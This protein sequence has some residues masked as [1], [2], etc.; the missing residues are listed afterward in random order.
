M[1][2]AR[3]EPRRIGR[4]TL[5][6]KLASGG[7]ATVFLAQSHGERG[8]L[9]LCAVKIIH[10]HLLDQPEFL[11]R[12]L[13]EGQVA[14][15]I[16]HP[17]VVAVL[18]VGQAGE[19]PYLVLDYVR[20]GSL[21]ELMKRADELGEPPSLEVACTIVR[22]VLEG[23]HAVHTALDEHGAPL[24]LIHRDVSHDNILLSTDGVAYVT[25]LGIA[26]ARG[27]AL[28]QATGLLGKAGYISPEQLAKEPLTSKVDVFAAGVVLWELLTQKRLFVDLEAELPMLTGTFDLEPPS[29]SNP[30]VPAALDG[31]VA[32]M[33]AR[34]PEDRPRSAGAAAQELG[35]II[36]TA[37]RAEISEWVQSLAEA[38]LER[39]DAI[40][41]DAKQSVPPPPVES[42][43]SPLAVVTRM[44]SGV[45]FASDASAPLESG[46]HPKATS[47]PPPSPR[48]AARKVMTALA[49]VSL[50]ALGGAGARYG[51]LARARSTRHDSPPPATSATVE[52]PSAPVPAPPSATVAATAAASSPA[53][54]APSTRPLRPAS[55]HGA[56]PRVRTAPPP[57]SA[58]AVPST[59][60]PAVVNP[61]AER[62]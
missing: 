37:T 33:L 26:R 45:A 27:V 23:L 59:A 54:V 53:P 14:S 29:R 42:S 22:E 19:T 28:T 39:L 46:A 36:P 13:H 18:D 51:L 52:A 16:R 5:L 48:G 32:R 7:M 44:G 57:P 50:L 58:T 62:L 55:G 56:P 21:A 30:R 49:V 31:L 8:F 6:A 24:G 4:Y 10:P 3:V 61:A 47:L 34:R 11:A 15:G 9:R 17:N 2:E 43:G 12:F 35:R 40:L 25:D 41:R 20:G 1:L 38:R 60:P